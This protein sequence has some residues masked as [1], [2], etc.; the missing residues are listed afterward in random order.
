MN[1]AGPRMGYGYDAAGPTPPSSQTSSAI[2]PSGKIL[3]DGYRND[4]M[5]GL[6]T[7]QPRYNPK[8]AE[9][10]TMP[11]TQMNL[12][13]TQ[14][15]VLVDLNDPIQVHLLTETALSD[16]KEYE[17]LS[18][19]EVDSLKKQ[20]TSLT[21]RIEQARANLAVQSKYLDAARSMAKLYSTKKKGAL[22][23]NV[24]TSVEGSAKDA[25]AERQACEKRCEDL[26]SELFQLERRLM[27]PQRRL[28]QHTAGILQLTHR[29][30]KNPSS[31]A[32]G[33]NQN[34]IP[35]SPESLYTYNNLRY[36][37]AEGSTEDAFFDD[38]SLY[39]TLEELDERSGRPTANRANAIAI[40]LKSPVREQTNQLREESDRLKMERDQLRATVDSV[41]LEMDALRRESQEKLKLVSLTERKLE[42]LSR[43]LRDLIVEL[44]PTK[45]NGYQKAPS[46]SLEPGD[47]IGSHLE[48]LAK[49]LV[50]IQE[51]QRSIVSQNSEGSRDAEMAASRAAATVSQ[52]ED[53]F[54]AINRQLHNVLQSANTSQRPGPDDFGLDLDAQF[55]WLQGSIGVI[56]LQLSQAATASSASSADKQKFIQMDSIL[57]DLWNVIQSG[58]AEINKRQEE[59]RKN[60]EEAGI[61]DDDED[62]SS[63]EVPFSPTEVYSLQAFQDK[64]QWLYAQATNLREQK[65]VLKRQIK[66]QRELNSKSDAQKDAE[67]ASKM[68]EL[69]DIRTML[70]ASDKAAQESQQ[71]LAQALKDL[72]DMKQQQSVSMANVSASTKERDEKLQKSEAQISSLQAEIKERESQI[73]ALQAQIQE[74]ESQAS[75]LQ[76]QI[77]E[78]DSQTTASQSQLQEKDSQIAASAQRLQERENRLA[79]IS[80]DLKARDVQLEG[81]RIISQDLQEKLD[82]VE[83]ELESVGAQLQ[84]ATEAKATAEAAAEKLEKEAK[85]KEEELERLNVMVIEVKTELTF[86]KAEL[87]GAYGSRSQRAAEVAA[88]GSTAEVSDLK[89][90]QEKLKAELASTLSEFEALTKD[91]IT[92][93]RERFDLEGKLDDALAAKASL[94]TEAAELRDKLDREVSK[95]QDQLDAERLKATS[96]TGAPGSPRPGAGASMLS[97]QFRAT[98]KEERRKFQEELRNEQA[99]RRKLEDEIRALKRSQGPGKS[100]LSPR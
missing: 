44:N 50:N 88:L 57:R 75:A 24:R 28:F 34:G 78:R 30:S 32:D 41:Q 40:P 38:R 37:I 26:A 10:L 46:G 39:M 51:E 82:Q 92:A 11:A 6:G 35:G 12:D 79:A 96:I 66:Q 18:Q 49:G 98:M 59:R 61:K 1:G 45:N 9:I 21:Q 33:A 20:V 4:I 90:Q 48:F 47:M 8:H 77:Q 17:I 42:G 22:L 65:S 13:R 99:Q 74:R 69:S 27:E 94:E 81:L 71:K 19:E 83:K 67:L 2:A 29:A 16:S 76:A 87:D 23:G 53:R 93:E 72:E 54:I 43:Q 7:S 64:V 91:T 95:L 62:A 63:D 58:Y 36:S 55:N 68:D 14:S 73:A 86:A 25:E 56:E 15:S 52:A 84:A 70:Q 97:E 85:E 100:P 31:L 3:M 60:R 5:G 89:T 80:E